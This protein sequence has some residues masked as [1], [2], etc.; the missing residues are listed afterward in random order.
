MTALMQWDAFA[1][2]FPSASFGQ[3]AVD[4]TGRVPYIA[5]DQAATETIFLHG[6]LPPQASGA[7]TLY[8][9][10]YMPTATA[11][12]AMPICA[13]ERIT[14]GRVANL[15]TGL[16]FSSFNTSAPLQVPTASGRE[17]SGTLSLATADDVSAGD[18][19]RLRFGRSSEAGGDVASGDWR[20]TYW[21]LRDAR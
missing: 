19:F 18:R 2:H 12:S 1:A 15:M 6:K 7:L 8:F 3:L 10:G 5:F 17:F 11:G 14:P 16:Y 9:A 13:V 21:E 20:V 4:L